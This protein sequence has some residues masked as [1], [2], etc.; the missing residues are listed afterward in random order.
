MAPWRWPW[1]QLAPL[2]FALLL[3]GCAGRDLPPA[4][5]ARA[6]SFE[7]LKQRVARIRGLSSQH[8]VALESGSL[9]ELQAL[10]E[11]SVIEE[12]G[13]DLLEQRARILTRLGLLAEKTDL[14][15]ALVELRLLEQGLHYD[16]RSGK[17]IVPPGGATPGLAFLVNPMG[18]GDETQSQLLQLYAL[19]RILQ[20]QNFRW[21]EQLKRRHTE[22][23]ALAVGALTKGDAVLVGLA[24]LLGNGGENRQKIIEQMKEAPRFRAEIEKRLAHLP[25]LLRQ[26][27]VFQYIQGS[28]FALWAYSL[29]GWEGINGLYSDPPRSTKQILHP[30]KYYVE[31][32]DPLRIT[33]WS[34]LRSMGDKKIMEETLG[35]LLIQIL[36]SRRLS[37][38]EAA[39]AAAGWLGDSLLV[40]QEGEAMILAWVTAWE[41]SE[42]A[43]QFFRSYRKALERRHGISLRP[44]RASGET[45]VTP[46]TSN[47]ALLLQINGNLV[48]FLD[49]VAQP[50]SLAMAEELWGELE[51]DVESQPFEVTRQGHHPLTVRR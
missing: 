5:P 43:M 41:N 31:R 20:E 12:R 32:H 47:Q 2:S 19:T 30:E 8:D 28:R 18:G 17:V 42:E 6:S 9:D 24:H 33:P 21:P 50:R 11:K 7:E 36:L 37:R 39:Q 4:P 15:K 16:S 45:L 1:S 26:E 38:E 25:E 35:E 51:T 22:D 44:T 49:G 14:P 40:F 48:F 10:V 23:M 46:A 13:R 27:A 3:W 34:L 29:K